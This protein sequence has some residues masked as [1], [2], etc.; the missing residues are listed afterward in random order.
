MK[1]LS[2]FF[3]ALFVLGTAALLQGFRPKTKSVQKLSF[4]ELSDR[5]SA[6]NDTLYVVNFWATWCKPCVK[7]LPYFEHVNEKFQ[8]RPVKVLL[9]SLDFEN[10]LEAKVRPLAEKRIPRSEVLLLTDTDYNSW[11]GKV[12]QEWQ[13]NIPA[14][15]F[16]NKKSNI[17]DFVSTTL[18]EEELVSKIEK[19]SSKIDN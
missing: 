7:E 14:T 9:V 16:V 13:G 3:I 17:K 8:G 19:L 2:F 1:N 11:M 15:L 18:E 4:E 10:E 12:D 5:I 6:E